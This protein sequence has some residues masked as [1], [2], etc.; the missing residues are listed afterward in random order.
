MGPLAALL[1]NRNFFVIPLGIAPQDGTLASQ[2]VRHK[3]TMRIREIISEGEYSAEE[4]ADRIF[5]AYCRKHRI[6]ISDLDQQELSS[7]YSEALANRTLYPI[8]TTEPDFYYHGTTRAK[9]PE[10]S[11]HGLVPSLRPNTRDA[12]LKMHSLH[13][14]FFTETIRNAEFYAMRSRRGQRGPIVLLRVRRDALP[15]IQPDA[16]DPRSG[17]IERT[18]DASQIEIWNGDAWVSLLRA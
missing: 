6:R 1:E 15:D 7:L 18:L 4:E 9:L 5:L 10:I 17:Y 12:S 11:R 2:D 13:R 16:Q 14:V 3:Y 8:P